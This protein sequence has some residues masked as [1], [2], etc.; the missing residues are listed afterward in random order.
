MNTI[1]DESL[2]LN[3]LTQDIRTCVEE[4]IAFKENP[5]HTSVW[6]LKFGEYSK[7][8]VLDDGRIDPEVIRNFRR[9]RLF[10]SDNP[11]TEI[12]ETNPEKRKLQHEVRLCQKFLNIL[13]EHGL[14]ELLATYPS[15]EVGNP[16]L[17]KVATEGHKYIFT[18]RW[19]KHIHQLAMLD[20]WFGTRSGTDLV[21]L[22]IGSS[23]GI[24]QY[25]MHQQHPGCHQILVDIPKQLILARYFLGSCYPGARIAG[26]TELRE[27]KSLAP[28]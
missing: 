23:Y 13:K 5:R 1:G 21:T 8:L 19:F 3:Q 17:Y 24:F 9:D 10:V 15:P 4:D 27:I 7:Q 18:H 11:A 25:L 14:L 12:T 26:I 6:N 2:L 22:D 16:H 20:R 28:E